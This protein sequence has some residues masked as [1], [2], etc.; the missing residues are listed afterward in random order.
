M[1]GLTTRLIVYAAFSAFCL[2]SSIRD[3]LSEAMFKHQSYD[4]S[5]IFV[6]FVYGI[7]TQAV[8]GLALLATWIKSSESWS[9]PHAVKRE[10]ALLNLF[11]MAAFLFYFL[12]IQSPIGAALNAF[13]DYGSGPIFTAIVGAALVGEPLGGRFA[14][15]AALS[16]VGLLLLEIRRFYA[17]DL[18]GVSLTGTMLALLSSVAGAFYQ[19]YFKV[20]LQK[21]MT[22]SSIILLRLM[23][24]TLVLGVILLARPALFRY[25]LLLDTALIGLFGFA[26]PLFLTLTVIQHV[27]IQSFAMLLFSYP[28]LTLLI[29]Q[30]M[31]YA[32]TYVSDI[33]AGGLILTGIAVYERWNDR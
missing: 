5:P 11:T 31:G 16:T 10:I 17:D 15:S 29:S 6:L 12:A 26:L 33:I 8:A 7:V 25:D 14:L 3:V 32:Q 9:W 30:S 21:G 22:K 23:G 27:K 19:V 28:V 18:S 13:I 20:L 2:L 1:Q 24:I 4:A